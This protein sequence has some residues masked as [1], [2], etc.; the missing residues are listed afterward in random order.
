GSVGAAHA[1]FI[2]GAGG[3]FQRNL[4]LNLPKERMDDRRELLAEMNRLNRQVEKDGDAHLLDRHQKQ[5]Y[6]MLLDGSVA[7]AL[8]LTRE[9]PKTVARYDTGAYVRPDGWSK[10]ARGKAGLYTG[11]ARALGKQLL[12]ARRL[13]EAGCGYVTIHAGYDGVWDMH[14]DGNNLNMKDG[15][16]AV[17]RCFDHAVAAFVEDCEA[18]RLSE[19]L[20]LLCC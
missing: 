1:P 17:G 15:M 13:C 19:R 18:R 20:L 4:R 8:D 6:Q 12:L 7:D 11:H 14:A 16:E 9:D 10:V 2:P 5:A 3:A